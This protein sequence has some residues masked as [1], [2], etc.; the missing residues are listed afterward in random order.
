MN[1]NRTAQN[2]SPQQSKK[3]NLNQLDKIIEEIYSTESAFLQRIADLKKHKNAYGKPGSE[4]YIM[5]DG[6]QKL[7]EGLLRKYSNGPNWIARHK[8]TDGIVSYSID[9]IRAK[10]YFNNLLPLFELSRD[11][12]ADARHSDRLKRSSVVFGDQR[13]L[14]ES[15]YFRDTPITGTQ[16]VL[17]YPLFLTEILRLFEA[18]EAKAIEEC[19]LDVKNR[20]LFKKQAEDAKNFI[21]QFSKAF[22]EATPIVP[23]QNYV[24]RYFE[25]LAKKIN[26]YYNPQKPGKR[27]QEIVALMQSVSSVI[28]SGD[29]ILSKIEQLHDVIESHRET[30][31]SQ[32]NKRNTLQRMP[33]QSHY[34]TFLNILLS[35]LNTLQQSSGLINLLKQLLKKVS[36]S[37]PL[38]TA[39][40]QVPPQQAAASTPSSPVLPFT[41][42]VQSS[43]QKLIDEIQYRMNQTKLIIE[44]AREFLQNQSKTLSNSEQINKMN[45]AKQQY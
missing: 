20:A 2:S 13:H 7:A 6:M 29:D 14:D 12:S 3:L 45:A 31:K 8:T 36:Q 38:Q 9:T 25:M 5:L 34:L 39:L 42:Q 44:S 10:E 41:P 16:R 30:I 1:S 17:K 27:T 15:T 33:Q 37:A 11:F 23:P 40:P 18:K 43:I 21:E 24:E 35:D 28:D 26:D 4:E 32:K 19:I 22:N